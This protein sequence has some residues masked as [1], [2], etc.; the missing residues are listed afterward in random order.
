[1]LFEHLLNTSFTSAMPTKL[2]AKQ[3]ESTIDI[4]SAL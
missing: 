2:A 4:G 3:T 1:M